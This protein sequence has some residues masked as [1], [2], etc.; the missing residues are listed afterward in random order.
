MIVWYDLYLLLKRGLDLELNGFDRIAPEGGGLLGYLSWKSGHNPFPWPLIVC[1]GT[2]TNDV[3]DM[4]ND[5]CSRSAAGQSG[6]WWMDLKTLSVA[7]MYIYEILQ[8]WCVINV[9]QFDRRFKSQTKKCVDVCG[10]FSSGIIELLRH[11]TFL[12]DFQTIRGLTPLPF[13]HKDALKGPL[14]K[15]AFDICNLR[16]IGHRGGISAHF[17]T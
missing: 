4:P 15:T 10:C 13:P 14:T 12:R 8:H 11:R 1:S 16:L 9:S 7:Y 3:T 2:K 5:R 17:H 6:V